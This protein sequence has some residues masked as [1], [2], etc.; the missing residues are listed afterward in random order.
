MGPT[1]LNFTGT[2]TGSPQ[3]QT[4]TLPITDDPLVEGSET[5]TLTLSALSNTSGGQLSITD[6]TGTLSITDNDTATVSV[7]ASVNGDEGPPTDASITVTQTAAASVDTVITLA[8]ADVTA[9]GGGTDFTC[10]ASVTI[11]AGTTFTVAPIAIND[12]AIVEAAE[13]FTATIG[14]ITASDPQVTLGAPVSANLLIADD[15]TATVRS[16]ARSVGTERVCA[17]GTRR[18]PQH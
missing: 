15:D 12:D 8:C 6:A 5:A 1:A 3:T 10:P 4:F 7:T 14:P 13:T 18:A 2:P 11:T 16:E 17:C 9:T